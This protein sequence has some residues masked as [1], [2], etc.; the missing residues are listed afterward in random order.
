MYVVY[1]HPDVFVVEAVGDAAAG[2]VASGVLGLV[3]GLE[4]NW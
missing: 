1:K 3:V 2:V 4:P